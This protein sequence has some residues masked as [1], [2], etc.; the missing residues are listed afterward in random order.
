MAL[1]SE[2]ST[3]PCRPVSLKTESRASVAV[4]GLPKPFTD[5]HIDMI[6][7]NALASWQ[8]LGPD[9]D[10]IVLG[11]EDGIAETALELGLK[12]SPDIR[13]NQHGTPLLSDAFKQAF[14]M[15]Q[16]EILIYCNC[17]VILFPDLLQAI[18]TVS[19][20]SRISS[21]VA[22]GRRTDLKVDQRL[23]FDKPVTRSQ[24][25]EDAQRSGRKAPVVC[26]E[27]FAFTR[28]LYHELPDFAVG[29]GNWD[30]WMIAHAKSIPV[31]VID[32]TAQ[33][34]IIHQDHSYQHLNQSRLNCYVSGE[35]AQR[36]QQLA[37][38]K[39]VIGGSTGTWCL[40]KN[41]L[42]KN[43]AAWLNRTFWLDLPRFARMVAKL[44][45]ER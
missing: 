6:Q 34:Q 7:R 23:D 30:N 20:D 18:D 32:L 43:R 45:F 22:F 31:P 42:Q 15:T 28:D 12:H 40:D 44:P 24:L 26:K 38:G 27:Y 11:S 41:G 14:E 16:A 35:E 9:V 17:D 21:F 29:R 8:H 3:L 1:Q 36:N 5:P 13:R 33:V 4:F 39:N 25:L 10:A 37:G 2:N 19:N